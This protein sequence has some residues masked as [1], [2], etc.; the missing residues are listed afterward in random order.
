MTV[1]ISPLAKA[2]AAR[3]IGAREGF[4]E[5]RL[6]LIRIASGAYLVEVPPARRGRS[7]WGQLIWHYKLIKSLKP[8]M[9]FR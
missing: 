8:R 5:G 2:M 7:N 6:Q 1:P 4:P 3:G 9:R